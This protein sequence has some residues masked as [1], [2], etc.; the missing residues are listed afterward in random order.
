MPDRPRVTSS[1]RYIG[2]IVGH[3]ARIGYTSIGYVTELAPLKV[4]GKLLS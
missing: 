2:E 4:Y 3:R 1:G